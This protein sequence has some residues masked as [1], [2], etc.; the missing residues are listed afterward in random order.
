MSGTWRA[1]PMAKLLGLD[2]GGSSLRAMV[3]DS[4]TDE[5]LF[6]GASGAANWSQTPF[7]VL[8][9]HCREALDGAP[10]VDAVAGCLSGLLGSQAIS[11]AQAYLGELTKAPSLAFPDYAAAYSSSPKG[12]DLL[13]IAGTGTLIC[14]M[15]PLGDLIKTSGGGP[16]L[17]GDPGSVYTICRTVLAEMLRDPDSGSEALWQRVEEVWETRETDEILAAFYKAP[18]RAF[19]VCRLIAPILN[20]WKA[21]GRS[22]IDVPG[23]SLMNLAELIFFHLGKAGINKDS[24]SL[25]LTGGLWSAD[26]ELPIWFVN[27]LNESSSP[28]QFSYSFPQREPVWG[29]CQLARRALNEN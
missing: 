3:V 15:T 18:D 17:G 13:I 8:D 19:Q 11:E 28:G 22:L 10:S 23:E 14:S 6:T 29:A 2:G 26:P 16:L 9:G 20:A 4:E 12:T 25:C 21:E 5:V 1:K 27:L 7:S 24:I